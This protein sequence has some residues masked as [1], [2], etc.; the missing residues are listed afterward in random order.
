MINFVKRSGAG[1]K[2]A[3]FK[4]LKARGDN[5][6]ACWLLFVFLLAKYFMKYQTD[7]SELN[8]WT[9]VY[10][11]LSFNSKWQLMDKL[12]YR[13]WSSVWSGSSWWLFTTRA[14]SASRSLIILQ[15]AHA[16]LELRPFSAWHCFGLNSC[17][18]TCTLWLLILKM[19]YFRFYCEALKNQQLSFS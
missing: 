19:F 11:R 10:N 8:H 18:Y 12:I 14:L 1:Q 3:V 13:C 2:C 15:E 4:L 6:L 16:R 9:C 7:F 5:T 17:W